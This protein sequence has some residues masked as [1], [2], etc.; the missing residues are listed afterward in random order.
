MSLD[1]RIRDGCHRIEELY[2]ETQG[3]CY[4]SFSGGKDS[5]VLLALVKMCEEIYTIPENAI[6]AV[7]SNTGIEMGVTVDFVKWVKDNYYQNLDVI[8]PVKPFAW[9]IENE[10]KPVRSKIKSEVMHAYQHSRTEASVLNLVYGKT[11][12]GKT[13]RKTRI[14]DKD[15]HMLHDD[16]PILASNKCCSMMKKKP[17]RAY[18]KEHGIK[19]CF[20][21][22]RMAEGG[23]RKGETLR[24]VA[25][26]GKICTVETSRGIRKYP[27]IDWSDQDVDEFIN[28]YNV[29]ISD[30][31]TKYGL[32]RTG[33]M[34]CPFAKDVDND[35]KYLFYHE[36]NRYKASMFWLKDVYIAQNV[37]LPFDKAYERERESGGCGM[38][39]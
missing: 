14:A 35:L 1:D 4:I 27:I 30:A 15:M 16:F 22:I 34:A 6:P 28:K 17:C 32:D 12:T 23:I 33:C 39:R 21:G 9:V 13:M 19:G 31:Y 26:G 20:I 25:T 10:G 24:R 5:T 36:P 11:T 37:E 8:Y 3:K 29:P 2:Y 18:E 7:F 38:S